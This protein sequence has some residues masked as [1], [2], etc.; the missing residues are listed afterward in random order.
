MSKDVARIRV[1]ILDLDGV[2]Y[3]GKTA[4]PGAGETSE[5]LSQ[6]GYQTYYFTN[7]S[8]RTRDSYVELLAGFGVVA[9]AD[10]IVTSA[11]LTVRYF[12]D[13]GALDGTPRPTVLVVGE[14]GLA[15]ELRDAGLRVIR[16]PGKRPADYVVVGMDRKFTYRKLHEAQQ[17]VRAGAKLIAT[18]RDATY[19]VEGNV[20]P[21]GGSIVAAVATASEVEPLLIGKP[22]G[23]SGELILGQAGVTADEAL[24]VGDRLETDIEMGRRCGMWTCMVLSGISHA[25]EIEGLPP[26]SRPHW[27][28]AG[29]WKLPE[30]LAGR[31]VHI[32][33]DSEVSAFLQR[34]EAV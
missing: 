29:I 25:G 2:I 4:I 20:I 7:N 8:T 9:D 23:R 11:S 34:E 6:R 22:S 1:V 14:G 27:V 33:P 24:M 13:I 28:I 3:R 5:W 26:E 10:H 21:G 15:S 31:P 18:N 19:P 17:T 32:V 30:L 12:H 16:R